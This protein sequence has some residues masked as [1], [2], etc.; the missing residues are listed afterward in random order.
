MLVMAWNVWMT[1]ISGR[2]VR[3]EIPPAAMAHA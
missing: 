2:S 3:A 1:V